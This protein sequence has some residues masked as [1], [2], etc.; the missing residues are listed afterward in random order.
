[1]LYFIAENILKAFHSLDWGNYRP[2]S[3]WHGRSSQDV[4]YDTRTSMWTNI[5]TVMWN[6]LKW[7]IVSHKNYILR[8]LHVSVGWRI[9][10]VTPQWYKM[11]WLVRNERLYIGCF[12]QK[13]LWVED[14]IY[15]ITFHCIRFYSILF[16]HWH[17]ITI[18][19]RI[20]LI[21]YYYHYCCR[22]NF[23]C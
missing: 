22:Y 18:Y 16:H 10:L 12:Q 3:L 2:T 5:T 13:C 9:L 21:S 7:L 4:S 8:G 17:I 11:D 23:H 15:S 14:H 20:L 6:T 1:M 19:Y